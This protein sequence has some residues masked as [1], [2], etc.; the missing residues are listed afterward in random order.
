MGIS[1]TQLESNENMLGAGLM[2]H[3]KSYIQLFV[4]ET[5]ALQNVDIE[6]L[7]TKVGQII[8][9]VDGD[10][11]SEGYQQFQGLLNDVTA[12]KADNT[13][14]KQ[15][16]LAVETALNT[17]EAAWK[18]EVARVESES[19]ARDAALGVRIDGVETT[20]ADYASARINKDV[21]HDGKIAALEAGQAT[22]IESIQAEV[23]RALA[24]EAVLNDSIAANKADIDAIKVREADYATRDNVGSG[25]AAFCTGAI[26]EIWKGRVMPTGLPMP[27]GTISA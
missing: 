7:S 4:S 18:A 5:A 19:K 20:I 3:L 27:D 26:G 16:L 24:K 12:L 1:Q 9:T 14:N 6:A 8:D 11:D 17:L 23:Q 10:P 13:T 15:R 25:M 22:I 21:E 2:Q